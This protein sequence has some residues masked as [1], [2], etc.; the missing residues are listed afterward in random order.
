[1]FV[2]AVKTYFSHSTV[3]LQLCTSKL[4]SAPSPQLRKVFSALILDSQAALLKFKHLINKT[5]VIRSVCVARN[6]QFNTNELW[7]LYY[8][9]FCMAFNSP[10]RL[11]V[12]RLHNFTL[13]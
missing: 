2:L 13:L 1:M 6:Q 9:L 7:Y 11:L 8:C 5:N 10:L 4:S 3:F 12:I